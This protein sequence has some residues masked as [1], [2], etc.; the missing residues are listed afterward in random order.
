MSLAHPEK[1]DGPYAQ[2]NPSAEGVEYQVVK[3]KKGYFITPGD[4][5]KLP[6]GHVIGKDIIFD[7]D[8]DIQAMIYDNKV[9]LVEDRPLAV[10]LSISMSEGGGCSIPE[11]LAQAQEQWMHDN[12]A[13][14]L[15]A[16]R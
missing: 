14:A 13:T 2:R 5:V 7:E 10:P 8:A 1:W 16:M 15:C 12:R 11:E 6:S 3:T 9:L 4:G